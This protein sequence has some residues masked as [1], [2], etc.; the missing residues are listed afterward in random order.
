MKPP[1]QSPFTKTARLHGKNRPIYKGLIP[2]TF[3]TRAEKR[4]PDI[5][6]FIV[7]SFLEY[8]DEAMRF[9][10]FRYLTKPIDKQRLFRNLK[11]ALQLYLSDNA[12]IAV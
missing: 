1:K 12:K 8:L 9:H 3:L 11:D 7:T 4:N 5:I 2:K 10:V 6:I